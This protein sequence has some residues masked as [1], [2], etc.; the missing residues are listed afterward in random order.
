MCEEKKD[1][2]IEMSEQQNIKNDQVDPKKKQPLGMNL[3]TV[4][5]IRV[6]TNKQNPSGEGLR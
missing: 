5:I 6:T 1:R 3:I 2:M 4:K